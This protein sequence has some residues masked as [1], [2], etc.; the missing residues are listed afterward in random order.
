MDEQTKDEIENLAGMIRDLQRR[1]TVTEFVLADLLA[2]FDDAAPSIRTMVEN[3]L[4][5]R[6]AA[7]KRLSQT[8]DDDHDLEATALEEMEAAIARTRNA[9]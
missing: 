6:I 7:A 5:E 2:A 3:T 4:H 9:L 8:D 1:Q